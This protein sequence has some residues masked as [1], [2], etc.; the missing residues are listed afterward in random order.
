MNNCAILRN[1][2]EYT[3]FEFDG[4]V[5]RFIT[6][7]KLERYTKVL[8]WDHGYLVVMAKYKN[9][10]E[11]EEY[12]DLLPILQNLYYDI[13]TF[14]NPIKE[15]RVELPVEITP[16]RFLSRCRMAKKSHEI[17]SWD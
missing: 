3:I 7:S 15:V 9:L 11:V 8:E 17:T 14:L 10:D 5:I 1:S 2:G 6:S 16:K 13:D 12:I 4:Q